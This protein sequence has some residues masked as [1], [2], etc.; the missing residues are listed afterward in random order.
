MRSS[1]GRLNLK[2][3]PLQDCLYDYDAISQRYV[4]VDVCPYD[5]SVQSGGGGGQVPDDE[6]LIKR[7][8]TGNYGADAGGTPVNGDQEETSSDGPIPPDQGNNGL[9]DI[10]TRLSPNEIEVINHQ[11]ILVNY[12]LYTITGQKAGAYSSK[13]TFIIP[14][15]ASGIYILKMQSEK[16]ST[17]RKLYIP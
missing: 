3:N 8:P 9:S 5:Y 13:E 2:F 10:K 17:T 7:E 14:I 15:S 1:D 12:E 11:G 6:V 16:G 4:D